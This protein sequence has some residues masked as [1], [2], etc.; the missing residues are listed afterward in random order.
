MQAPLSTPHVSLAFS[1]DCV[2]RE[3]VNSKSKSVAKMAAIIIYQ[4]AILQ[5]FS[6]IRIVLKI[7]EYHPDITQFKLSILSHV[8]CLGQSRSSENI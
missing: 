8:T 4:K 2:N 3:A 1:L 5:I 6:A 7:W